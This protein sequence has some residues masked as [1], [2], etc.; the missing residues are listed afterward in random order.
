[1]KKLKF[2]TANCAATFESYYLVRENHQ[3]G[4]QIELTI[5]LAACLKSPCALC[6]GIRHT[7]LEYEISS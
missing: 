3:L 6:A 7:S 5:G 1:M 2:T 4:N